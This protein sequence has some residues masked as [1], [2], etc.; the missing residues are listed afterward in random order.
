VVIGLI[1]CGEVSYKRWRSLPVTP[2][3]QASR[4]SF[5]IGLR[6]QQHHHGMDES[7]RGHPAF[8]R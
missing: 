6:D 5:A 7:V 8:A 1:L 3:V 4:R 2:A